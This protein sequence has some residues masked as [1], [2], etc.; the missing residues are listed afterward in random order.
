MRMNDGTKIPNNK[1]KIDQ[2]AQVILVASGK[3]GV[4]KSTIS[5][6]LAEQLR[7]QGAKIG[8]ID[9]DIYGPSIPLMM[10]INHKPEVQNNKIIPL[11]SR[12]IKVMSIGFMTGASG[13]I[14]WRG[15]MTTKVIHQLLSAVEWGKLDYLIIDTPPGT[16]DI[17]LS[18]LENYH[19][20]GVIMVTTPQKIA[21]SDV[22]KG[23]DLYKKFSVPI[24]GIVENMSDIFPGNNGEKVAAEF[25]IP[26]IAKLPFNKEIAH[27]S[28]QGKAIGHLIKRVIPT[29]R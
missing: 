28:D 14:A 11:E 23:I 17:H 25:D 2:I 5:V 15:P 3:G 29:S 24:L 7:A 27:E 12:N 6:A 16:G 1:R 19:I 22:I 4:G 20:D 9:A 18:L 21:A 8:L 13:A 10:G 26:L